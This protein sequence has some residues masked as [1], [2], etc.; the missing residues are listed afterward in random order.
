M[1]GTEIDTFTD[2][3]RKL[4]EET[5]CE[6]ERVSER[7]TGHSECSDTLSETTACM[8]EA[9][10]ESSLDAA[11]LQAM[12]MS[13]VLQEKGTCATE[14]SSANSGLNYR[15]T[16]SMEGMLAPVPRSTPLAVGFEDEIRTFAGVPIRSTIMGR[17]NPFFHA[18]GEHSEP[19]M[20]YPALIET[21]NCVFEQ[22]IWCDFHTGSSEI[23]DLAKI[24]G[25]FMTPDTHS[26]LTGYISM[27][28]GT[29]SAPLGMD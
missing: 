28:V 8:N 14:A 24:I 18:L 16:Q 3:L 15:G 26:E 29:R 2:F 17:D 5:E 1:A 13:L 12:Q 11:I 25:E 23:P 6:T 10:A 4:R 9:L 27:L 7:E 19:D 22:A 20:L 21:L